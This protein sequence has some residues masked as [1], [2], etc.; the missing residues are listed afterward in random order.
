[1][2]G[3]KS[4]GRL[5]PTFADIEPWFILW[6][7]FTCVLLAAYFS[8]RER[9]VFLETLCYKG[10][11]AKLNFSSL[12]FYSG[13]KVVIKPQKLGVVVTFWEAFLCSYWKKVIL[14]RI[15]RIF[16]HFHMKFNKI[17]KLPLKKMNLKS[18]FSEF[19]KWMFCFILMNFSI[20]SVIHIVVK[21]LIKTQRL[22]SR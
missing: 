9:L 2:I 21:I 15:Q 20:D 17:K 10:N 3:I 22:S 12:C 18:I 5:K 14:T 6:K 13:Q 19:V 7:S 16:K 8:I 11:F 1:M 4:F